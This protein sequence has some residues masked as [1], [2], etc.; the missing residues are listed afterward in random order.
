MWYCSLNEAL[1]R[2]YGTKVYK[3]ALSCV[4]T[5]PN[6][7]GTVGDRGCI[8]CTGAG[9]FAESGPVSE[10]LLRAKARLADKITAET[11]Y[12]AYF[13]S[14]TNTYA[15]IETLRRAFFAAIEPEDVVALSIATR[16]DC[17]GAEVL[18]LL[19]EVNRRKPVWVEM[20]L[21]TTNPA[22]ARYIRRGCDLAAFDAAIER[23]RSIGI[24]VILHQIIGLPGETAEDIFATADYIAHAG[25]QG[26][27][28][29]LLYVAEGTDL[30]EEYRQGRVR[31]LEPE[32][33]FSLL[34]GC[35]RRMP[36]EMV[37]HRLTGDGAKRNLLAPLWSGNK[38]WVLNGIR[39]YF[40][41]H[42]VVQGSLYQR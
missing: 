23:L 15:S 10:Q 6:R 22:T 7:D 30:A 40:T 39:R 19:S 8:F 29:H 41:E 32:E 38:K 25:V 24:T 26:V 2:S 14:F 5:C 17:L 35:I 18:S 11:R 36:P 13:Q 20:G 34:S 37:I 3:L 1:R 9:E 31:I 16:P 21:Q 33:Y 42:D 4:N 12:V 27:K 28:F